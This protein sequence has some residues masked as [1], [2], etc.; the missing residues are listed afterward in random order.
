M[1]FFSCCLYKITFVVVFVSLFS[2]NSL[3]AVAAQITSIGQVKRMVGVAVVGA[4]EI[5]RAAVSGL[6][7]RVGESI[8]TGPNT[9]VELWLRDGSR[10][11]LGENTHF[12][13]G[14]YSYSRRKNLGRAIFELVKG[15]FQATSGAISRLSKPVFEVRTDY[16]TI[17]IRGTSFWGGFHFGN[18]L[19]VAL[20]RGHGV[21]VRND[22]GKVELTEVGS[23]TTVK[24][25]SNAPDVPRVWGSTK[26]EAAKASVAWPAQ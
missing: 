5:K 15:V 7:V 10:V 9:R 22:A 2:M 3:S 8:E 23:G 4:D 16:A 25:P 17:G 20:L 11:T 13:V 6:P 12:R 19:S 24:G 26:L 1:S 18:D 21:Y 14:E